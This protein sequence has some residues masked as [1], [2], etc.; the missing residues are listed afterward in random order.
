MGQAVIRIGNSLFKDR[1]YVLVAVGATV[2]NGC[3]RNIG[4]GIGPGNA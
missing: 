4:G 1:R 3:S 2:R